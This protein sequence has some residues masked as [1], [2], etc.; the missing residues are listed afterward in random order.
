MAAG[1]MLLR[2]KSL[3]SNFWQNSITLKEAEGPW[4]LQLPGSLS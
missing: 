1:E 3:G 4:I 2:H